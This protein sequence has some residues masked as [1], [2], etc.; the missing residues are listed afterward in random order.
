M[1]LFLDTDDAQLFEAQT[2]AIS[3]LA[4]LLAT[5]CGDCAV[6][7]R[8]D[9]NSGSGVPLCPRPVDDTTSAARLRQSQSRA[10]DRVA[11]PADGVFNLFPALSDRSRL[12]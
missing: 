10:P 3:A 1:G 12:G 9:S 6:F 7:S 2:E 4:R 8:K 11:V 5:D